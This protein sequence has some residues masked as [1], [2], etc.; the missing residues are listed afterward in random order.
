MSVWDELIWGI[1]TRPAVWVKADWKRTRTTAISHGFGP[2]YLVSLS[3]LPFLLAAR[4]RSKYIK[5][6]YF[7][8]KF[9]VR[10]FLTAQPRG[11]A[12]W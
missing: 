2:A 8:G 7:A 5:V 6:C 1:L 3:Y 11:G 4:S 12:Q 10:A 9:T